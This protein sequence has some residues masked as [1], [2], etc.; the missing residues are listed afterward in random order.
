MKIVT[1]YAK[2]E[3]DEETFIEKTMKFYFPIEIFEKRKENAQAMLDLE[4]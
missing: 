2:V 4:K 3:I 1:T